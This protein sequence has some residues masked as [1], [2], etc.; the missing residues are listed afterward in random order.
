MGTFSVSYILATSPWFFTRGGVVDLQ[1]GAITVVGINGY[2]WSSTASTSVSIA[3][4]LYFDAVKID[5]SYPHTRRL[6]FSVRCVAAG[7][8][9]YMM[10]K[11][12]PLSTMLD[13]GEGNHMSYGNYH[14]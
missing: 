8:Q 4:P 11:P 9:C 13:S 10:V 14:Q 2:Y 12:V 7:S 5:P 1:R 6:G 3:Y